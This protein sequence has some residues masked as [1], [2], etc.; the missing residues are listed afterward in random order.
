MALRGVH[1]KGRAPA[2]LTRLLLA[3][4]RR[5]A[6]AAPV[7]VLGIVSGVLIWPTNAGEN[8]VT[9]IEAVG[10][11]TTDTMMASTIG[12]LEVETRSAAVNFATNGAAVFDIWNRHAIAGS[13]DE[14][15]AEVGTPTTTV[16]GDASTTVVDG[17]STT[18]G[19][20]TTTDATTQA[21]TGSSTTRP[22]ATTTTTAPTTTTRGPTTTAPTT[23]A[24]PTT[25]TGGGG[26]P[27]IGGA[28]FTP[29]FREDF[30]GNALNSNWKVYTTNG[31]HSPHAVRRAEAISVRDGKLIITAKNDGSGTAMSGGLRHI[32]NQT[33]GRFTVRVRTD[34]DMS[35]A[36]SG[37]VLTWPSSNNQPRDG[38]N[39]LYETLK[40]PGSRWPFY[41]FI[42][43][44]FD[45]AA[46]GVSQKRF[47]YQ[48][49]ATQW[50]EVSMEWTPDYL[51]VQRKGPGA[52]SSEVQRIDETSANRITDAEHFLSI[53]L[54]LFKGSFPDNR[55]VKMEVDWVEIAAYCGQ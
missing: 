2:A 51:L 36:T 52:Q 15:V 35:N 49:D 55:Q 25:T 32:G 23:T 29:T 30:N 39:N 22:S 18:N 10:P 28:C 24:G 38:E 47:V 7:A 13:D 43:E 14:V 20:S 16:S 8:G 21:T 1:A 33:Y 19:A 40:A 37:V 54:D 3:A 26:S 12:E 44:P 6:L 48:A 50:Q 31:G 34:Q 9:S 4:G 11:S 46:D 45:D 17:S 41:S 27:G 53:Q 42:H 5:R